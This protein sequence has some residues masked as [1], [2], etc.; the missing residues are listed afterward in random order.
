MG[1]VTVVAIGAGNRM[2]AYAEL[3]PQEMRVVAV[4]EP[5]RIRRTQLA[6]KCGVE[7]RNCFES[8]EE[9]FRQEKMAD[10]VFI[11]TPDH[12]HYEPAMLA[13]ERGYDVLL[14]KPIAQTLEVL[15]WYRYV[16]ER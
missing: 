14:E 12:I 6:V 2:N 3:H 10:A 7:E 1:K 9:F 8:W 16:W 5:N 15:L 11:C 13:L 4:V